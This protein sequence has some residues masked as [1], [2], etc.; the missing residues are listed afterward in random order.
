MDYN[1]S[2]LYRFYVGKLPLFDVI[3]F[4]KAACLLKPCS[5]GPCYVQ[6]KHYRSDDVFLF[7]VQSDSFRH[8]LKVLGSFQSY[9]FVSSH[10]SFYWKLEILEEAA[11]RNVCSHSCFCFPSSLRCI[12]WHRGIF[13]MLA[14]ILRKQMCIKSYLTVVT[15][16][17]KM[18]HILKSILIFRRLLPLARLYLS[19]ISNLSVV[20]IW[21]AT[22]WRDR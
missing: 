19:I 3:L 18:Y 22:G 12:L 10:K 14:A 13:L 2:T 7:F 6:G 17:E 8:L 4:T 1:G 11:F 15:S 9:H 21:I 20:G 16:E 5:S